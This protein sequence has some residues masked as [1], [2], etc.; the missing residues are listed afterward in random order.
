MQLP[1]SEELDVGQLSRL[2]GNTSECYK[3]FWFKAI[4]T[5]IREGR[6]EFSF[7][8]L[9]NEMIAE[10]WYMVTEYHLNLGPRDNLEL[11]VL[12]LHHTTGIKPSEKKSVILSCLENCSDKFVVRLKKVLTENVPY[13]LLAPFLP[14]LKSCDFDCS[15]YERINKI[16]QHQRLMYYFREYNG[17]YTQIGMDS[18]WIEYIK[19]NQE[20]IYGWLQYHMIIYLQKRNPSVPGIADKLFPPVE[21]KLEKVKRYWKAIID[22]EPVYD[23]YGNYRLTDKD[24]SI[25]HFVP[26]S[27]VAHDELWNLH[28][29]TKSI[30]SQKSNHLPNWEKYFSEFCKQEYKAYELIWRWNKVH[31]AFERCAKEHINSND[32]R[33]RLYTKGLDFHRFS[34]QL[35]EVMLPVYQS[36]KNCGFDD[37]MYKKNE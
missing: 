12:H 21:R 22:V 17:I 6:C 32:V 16:N 18:D 31:E 27:Y 7:E 2:F 14:D 5:K 3:F 24:I 28:P 19:K 34:S 26:W 25:D 35:E 4:L 29:T 8:E 1:Y 11:L 36:A 10:A 33:I 13:R 9:V 15:V 23:I 20:I 37:W 30:N